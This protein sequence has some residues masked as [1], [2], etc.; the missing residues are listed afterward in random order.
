MWVEYQRRTDESSDQTSS[1]RTSL[2][3]AY[4]S[5][6]WAGTAV[7]L[8]GNASSG[9]YKIAIDGASPVSGAGSVSDI[10]ASYS[11]LAYGVHTLTLY[12]ADDILVTISGATI[13]TGM[14]AVGCALL[15]ISCSI[16]RLTALG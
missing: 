12:V 8:Y 1:H 15:L 16:D 10:L 11:G 6:Q 7:V 4:V 2:F 3:G 9:S 13:T 14:G 5:L